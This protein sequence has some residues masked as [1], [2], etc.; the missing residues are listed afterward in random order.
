MVGSTPC[1]SPAFAIT[2]NEVLLNAKKKKK[3]ASKVGSLP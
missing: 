1:Q 3:N 2:P